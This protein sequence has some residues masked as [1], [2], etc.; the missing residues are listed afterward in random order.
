MQRRATICN[1]SNDSQR[2]ATT[3]TSRNDVQQGCNVGLCELFAT[4]GAEKSM[5]GTT[6]L[7]LR[8][9]SSHGGVTSVKRK[10]GVERMKRIGSG[11]L[12]VDFFNQHLMAH[13]QRI[14]WHRRVLKVPATMLKTL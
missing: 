2:C 11:P 9:V 4:V 1:D 6:P 7:F 8:F 12:G 5:K 13:Y 14:S 3:A 10:A